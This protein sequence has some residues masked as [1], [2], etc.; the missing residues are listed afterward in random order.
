MLVR[1]GATL[2]TVAALFAPSCGGKVLAEP[3]IVTLAAVQNAPF[4][5]V[6]N[7][8]S[9]Y[10]TNTGSVSV[11]IPGSLAS[12]GAYANGAIMKMPSA[13]GVPVTLAFTGHDSPYYIALDPANVYWTSSVENEPSSPVGSLGGSVTKV[14]LDGGNPV[15]LATGFISGGLA[16]S[17]REVFWTHFGGPVAADSPAAGCVCLPSPCSGAEVCPSIDNGAVMRLSPGGKPIELAALGHAIPAGVA[18]DA[19]N[20]YWTNQNA[21]SV[22]KMPRSGGNPTVLA[23][24]QQL[25]QDIATD[26]TSVYWTTF[27]GG[28]RNGGAIVKVATG[29]GVPT[30]LAS[31]QNPAGIAVDD[32]NVYWTNSSSF[33][34]SSD[35][36]A[37]GV[38]N[39]DGSVMKVPLG[40]GAPVVVASGQANPM[41]IAVDAA[42]VYWANNGTDNYNLDGAIMK[43]T[44]K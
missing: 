27:G 7:S 42:S 44:P 23:T 21:G 38:T 43:R 15:A 29:G 8:T 1:H 18:L 6:V 26:S 41:G 2:S 39:V 37:G 14:A 16:A 31:G 22:M 36:G 12:T 24:D 33:S 9:V 35:G 28:T 3:G 5:V 20:V 40:G 34:G 11:P 13:G 30:T 4:D 10:W 32:Q 19:T 17:S 25:P